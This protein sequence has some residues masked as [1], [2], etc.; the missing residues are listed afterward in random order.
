MAVL[1]AAALAVAQLV[2][3][4]WDTTP[5]DTASVAPTET[6]QEEPSE[7]PTPLSP[8]Q[9]LY[10]SYPSLARRM[11]CVISRESKW[12]PSATNPRSGAAGLAQFLLSTWLTTPP[13]R[14][15]ASRY[16][17]YANIDGAAW[18]ATHGGW[19]HW[20]VVQVGFC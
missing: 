5:G 15:G 20:T 1:L 2:P 12:T 8:Y 3:G 10:A 7:A 19:R 4:A 16:D 14:A 11:D 17:P 13:G 6:L 9:Y 18:L